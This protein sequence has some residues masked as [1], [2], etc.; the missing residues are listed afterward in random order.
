MFRSAREEM[1]AASKKKRSL[2]TADLRGDDYLPPELLSQLP[3]TSAIEAE[4]TEDAERPR[5]PSKAAKAAAK[6]AERR[7]Q[8]REPEVHDGLPKVVQKSSNV[9]VALLPGGADGGPRLHAPV[10]SDAKD[11][12]R[13]QL[14][15]ERQE[16]RP[17]A[18][19]ASLK[20]SGGRAFGAASNFATAVAAPAAAS[21]RKGKKRKK[22]GVTK[23]VT[24]AY[25][26]LER[27]AAKLMRRKGA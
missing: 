11:F 8:P 23:E 21:S 18:S 4:A 9:E 3:A 5:R 25:S 12:M 13:K 16:R 24:G 10:T 15:G 20:P 6:A 7:A 1:R 27:M 17:A 14:Y 22:G 26:T 2:V 19:I